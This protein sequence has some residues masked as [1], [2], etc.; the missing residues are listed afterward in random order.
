MSK[1]RFFVVLFAIFFGMT[2]IQ[3]A[4]NATSSQIQQ[5]STV[6]IDELSDE[7]IAV[8][9]QKAQE[10]GYTLD[11]LIIAGRTRGMSDTQAMKLRQRILQLSTTSQ[12]TVS[13]QKIS[14]KTKGDDTFGYTGQENK[15]SL[16]LAQRKDSI[17]GLN[18]FRNPKISFT[19]N[20]N[21]PTP[22]NYQVGSGDELLIEV[23]GATENSF[24]QTVDNQGNIFLNGIGKINVSGLSFEEVKSKINSYLKRIYSGIN[25]PDNSYY[26]IYTGVTI[27]QV[28]TVKV[29]IIGEVEVPGTYSISAM[30]TVLNAL[31]ASGGPTE[32][33]SFREINVFRSGEKIATFDIYEFLV[34]GS[35]SGNITLQDQDVIIVPPYKNRVWVEGEVKRKGA[36]ETK[37]G[38]TL[39][40]LIA[41]FGG[42]NADA[43]TK[44]LVIERVKDAKREVREIAFENIGELEIANGDKLTVH[45]ITDEYQNKLS[46]GG[47]VY[48]PGTYEFKEGMT[49]FDLLQR[50]NGVRKEAS[51]ER[52]LIFRTL[53]RVDI[54]TIS[55]SVEDLMAQKEN[56]VL[57]DNDSL[58]VFFKDSLQFARFIKIEGAVNKPKTIPYM[59]GMT[60]EDAIALAGGFSQGADPNVIDIFRLVNEGNFEKLSHTYKVSANTKN[61]NQE[62]ASLKPDDLISVRYIK[63]FTPLQTV[64]V[65]G[66]VSFPGSY[67]IK[68]KNERISDLIERAGGFS[69]YAY[70]NG[71]TLV[72]K[73]LD[74]GEKQREKFINELVANDN[75]TFKKID[76]N[77][78]DFR[79]G[80][81][82]AKI[83]EKKHSK[84]DLILNEGDI[85]I[86]PSERQT[87]EVKGEVLAP[88]L[89]RYE[90]GLTLRDYINRAGGFTTLAKKSSVYV[91]YAN[92]DV[93]ATEISLFFKN[94][95][96]LEPGAVIIVP[97]KPERRALSTGETIS[98]FTALTT[99]GV[100]I[101]N[102]IK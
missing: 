30:S 12:N 55:F 69:P 22:E 51:L 84:Y 81:D 79:I 8:Y 67:S 17:F 60:V 11:Q 78:S 46:I 40:N 45:K 62:A 9:W 76:T 28:R 7:Q 24:E 89:I 29:N 31:Y 19:P 63:G 27:S 88:S 64:S 3:Y 52:G 56:I 32:N 25:A 86:V 13:N 93:K 94:Y 41:F 2:H 21:M 58:H 23:W 73:K 34:R 42:F 68:T 26:K 99:M 38:E 57:K 47:A 72:R 59:E 18:F 85:I 80:I 83:M 1:I 97:S 36:Y 16:A 74:E 37:N 43:Y 6:N 20:T 48:Q 96:V 33:G 87:I 100:L 82:L 98:I 95:P 54:Q 4:Q 91:M 53:N 71:A 102:A 66:E 61:S 70:V 44:T 65:E 50:A 10:Q 101:Y 75:E 5:L 77:I 35:E 39:A 90:K 15:G 14:T 92:G 49:A